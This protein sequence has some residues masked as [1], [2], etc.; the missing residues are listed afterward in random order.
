[1]INNNDKNDRI[2]TKKTFQKR[3]DRLLQKFENCVN[4]INTSRDMNNMKAKP[5]ETSLLEYDKSK[6]KLK[7][8]INWLIYEHWVE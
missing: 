4:D 3:M 8:S 7:N 6:K 2:L 1:M 5:I